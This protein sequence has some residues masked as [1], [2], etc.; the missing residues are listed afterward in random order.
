MERR[1]RV[2]LGPR[3]R[4]FVCSASAARCGTVTSLSRADG[5]IRIP[6]DCEGISAGEAVRAELLR[7]VNRLKAPLLA[8]GS[9]D[10]TLELIDSFL[11]RTHPRFRLTSAQSDLLGGLLALRRRQCHLAGLSPAG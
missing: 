8:I 7:R 5:V 11:R 9:H 4:K 6:R 10:N 3:G 2:K 1:V